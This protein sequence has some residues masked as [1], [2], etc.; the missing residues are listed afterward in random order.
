MLTDP[1]SFKIGAL[2]W[3][4]NIYIED[5]FSNLTLIKDKQKLPPCKQFKFFLKLQPLKLFPNLFPKY[6]LHV[7]AL[8][9]QICKSI[10]YKVILI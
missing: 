2:F 3:K 8:L 6:N 1:V 4:W 5:I 7:N 9:H 10:L